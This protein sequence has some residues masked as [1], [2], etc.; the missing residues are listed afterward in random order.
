MFKEITSKLGEKKYRKKQFEHAIFRELV[1]N[2]EQITVFPKELREKLKKEPFFQMEINNLLITKDKKTNKVLFKTKDNFF[3]ES[4]LMRHVGRNTVCVSSQIGCPCACAFCATGKMGFKRNLSTQEI[5]EQVLFWARQL[6]KEYLEEKKGEWNP[7]NPPPSHRVRN[8]VFMGMGEP[9]LNLDNVLE[10]IKILN[11]D[12]KFGIGARRI[13]I[14]TVGII[15]QI[16][17]LTE[18][19]MQINLAV[20]LHAPENELRSQL[21]P[22]NKVFPLKDLM[23]S[24]WDFSKKTLRRIFFEY[25]VIDNINDSEQDAHNLGKLLQNKLAHVNFIPLNENPDV[26]KDFKKPKME[27]IRKMQKILEKYDLPSTVRGEFGDEIAGACG[28]LAGKKLD[29]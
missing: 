3:I 11:D 25:T 12:H 16:K 15:P 4:V 24:L 23:Q 19:D 18:L 13:T 28:Q 10:A 29:K 14:S 17:K 22:Q 2:I 7:K 9:L 21:I 5:I 27:K 26:N 8:I 20:S 1:E 6:K